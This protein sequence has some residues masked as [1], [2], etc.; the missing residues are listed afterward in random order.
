MRALTLGLRPVVTS[1]HVIEGI[2][3]IRQ[4]YALYHARHTMANALG[5]AY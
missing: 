5:R 4:P 2:V 1:R 3:S